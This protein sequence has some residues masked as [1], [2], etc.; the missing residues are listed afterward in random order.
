MA[1]GIVEHRR[2]VHGYSHFL[3]QIEDQR[4]LVCQE[5]S[6]IEESLL[7]LGAV[8]RFRLTW[9][10]ILES[11]RKSTSTTQPGKSMRDDY[12]LALAL[13]AVEFFWR[14]RHCP[15]DVPSQW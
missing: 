7:V 15:G 12:K 5:I 8:V 9:R 2:D 3:K 1:L 14:N 4:E 6:G 11:Y 13:S 10:E